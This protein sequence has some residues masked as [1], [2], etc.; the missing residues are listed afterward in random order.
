MKTWI[1]ILVVILIVACEKEHSF[2]YNQDKDSIYFLKTSYGV[3]FADTLV[4]RNGRDV[5]L[6]D[7]LQETGVHI[8]VAV[9]GDTTNYDRELF[10]SLIPVKG[11]DSSRLAQIEIVGP[12]ILRA[13][14]LQDTIQLILKRPRERQAEY[15]IG[16]TFNTERGEFAAGPLEKQIYRITLRDR[17]TKPNAWDS[18][19]ATYL[20]EWLPEK[21]AFVVTV[22]ES[23]DIPGAGAMMMWR[24]RFY[25]MLVNALNK[26]NRENPDHQKEFTFPQL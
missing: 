9:L 11:Q 26:F 6:G 1:Y 10:F 18:F 3:N 20:G 17:Y 25:P 24:R 4:K 21:H 5:F 19:F 2:Y 15:V 13:G 16:L 7:S 23:K 8:V 14:R 22:L 12:T